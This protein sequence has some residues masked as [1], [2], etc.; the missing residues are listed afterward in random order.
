MILRGFCF[1]RQR[2]TRRLWPSSPLVVKS[3]IGSG[4]KCRSC[5]FWAAHNAPMTTVW[6]ILVRPPPTSTTRCWALASS[7]CATPCS[8]TVPHPLSTYWGRWTRSR[9]AAQRRFL[10]Q[11]RM[12]TRCFQ[13]FSQLY[14]RASGALKPRP[15]FRVFETTP[16]SRC[17]PYEPLSHQ[18]RK[19]GSPVA[20]HP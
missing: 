6:Q 12:Q 7:R 8:G 5:A 3:P 17:H 9:S 18:R 16:H 11:L 2:P 10:Q 19:T 14:M 13:R 20:A 15:I 1:V 4:G